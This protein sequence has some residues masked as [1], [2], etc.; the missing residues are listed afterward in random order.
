MNNEIC[1]KIQEIMEEHIEVKDVKPTTPL[2]ELDIDSLD[3]VE[4]IM[5]IEEEFGVEFNNEE[6]LNLKCF[7][8]IVKLVEE[9]CKK[10]LD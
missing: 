7:N 6:I 1:K 5:D 3:L 9:K 8:D 10:T 2:S 4:A